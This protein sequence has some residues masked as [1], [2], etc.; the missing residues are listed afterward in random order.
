MDLNELLKPYSSHGRTIEGQIKW[1]LSKGIPREHIDKAILSVYDEIARG[2]TFEDGKALD[3]YL[4]EV[5]HGHHQ[6]ELSESIAKLEGFFN[7]LMKTHRDEAAAEVIAKI[8]A[9]KKPWGM[10]A[11][12]GLLALAVAENVALAAWWFLR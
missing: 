11:L 10:Y 3:H 12:I 8:G 9:P 1:L 5:A 2:R 7:D 6:S 4:L